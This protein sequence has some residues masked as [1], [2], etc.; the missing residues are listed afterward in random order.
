MKRV[1]S[2]IVYMFIIGALDDFTTSLILKCI[3][4]SV[5]ELT[6]VSK[7]D[8][9]LLVDQD[10]LYFGREAFKLRF[11]TTGK[12]SLLISSRFFSLI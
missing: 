3:V 10:V 12:F 4:M 11:K 1:R 5:N 8:L 6:N 2:E 7:Q 9:I